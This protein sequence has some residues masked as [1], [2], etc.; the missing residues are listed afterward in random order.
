METYNSREGVAVTRAEVSIQSCV[1]CGSERWV[2]TQRW[3]SYQ[4]A[5]CSECGLTFTVNP[6]YRAGRYVVTY[7]GASGHI[8]VPEEQR[9]VYAQPEQRLKM[10]NLAFW[11]PP[12]RLTPAEKGALKMAHH[13]APKH[14]L[15]IDCVCG[16]GRFQ[17]A[18]QRAGFQG[19]GVEVSDALVASLNRCGSTTIKGEVPH[20]PWDGAEPYAITFFEVLEHLP[21]PAEVLLRLRVR[22][23]RSAI[24]AS[25]PS[26]CRASRCAMGS[27]RRSISRRITSFAGREGPCRLFFSGWKFSTVVVEQPPPIGSELMLAL[28]QILPRAIKS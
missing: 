25:V 18:L 13:A 22:F 19:L 9:Y 26:P 17:R 10:E 2:A 20:F 7:E 23:P 4:L 6:D 5:T 21:D 16:V 15:V 24:L 28:G 3:Q 8:P 1:A 14:A 27:G 11:T 12:P